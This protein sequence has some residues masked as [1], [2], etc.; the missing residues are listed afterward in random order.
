MTKKNDWEVINTS[1]STSS[2]KY[3]G[4]ILNIKNTPQNN[5]PQ[6]TQN[7]GSFVMLFRF[8][9]FIFP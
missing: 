8:G 6:E 3:L 5:N 7:F 1:S 9:F 2:K 4:I